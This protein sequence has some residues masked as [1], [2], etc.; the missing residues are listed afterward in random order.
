LHF[1]SNEFGFLAWLLDL[2]FFKMSSLHS[3]IYK[4]GLQ[5]SEDSSA[6]QAALAMRDLDSEYVVIVDPQGNWV[7]LVSDRDLACHLVANY[8]MPPVPLS[9]LMTPHP[10]YVKETAKV[11]EV[12]HL[13]EKYSIQ[14][15]PV[16]TELAS[17]GLKCIGVITLEDL[18][19]SGEVDLG[20]LSRIVKKR[21]IQVHEPKSIR[22]AARSL[23]RSQQSLQEFYKIVSRRTGLDQ[24]SSE[25][26]VDFVLSAL[27]QRI[28]PSA[29]HNFI[30]QLPK[31]MQELL[32]SLPPGPD[33]KITLPWINAMISSKFDIV[34]S[35][36]GSISAS[37][38][39]GITDYV[40][41][42]ELEH[43]L[44]QLPEPI[45]KLFHAEQSAQ[46]AS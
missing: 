39:Q 45:R 42:G 4:K 25:P 30:A 20:D 11:A 41:P 15:V 31:K 29:A 2:M 37:I 44:C 5:L 35:D 12:I 46:A 14:F 24:T 28:T 21:K 26:V 23:A 3:L 36:S 17:G 32:L 16:V 43:L 9:Q 7:G 6:Q 38:F 8:P 19:A 40:D 13:M 18:I 27:V 34:P 22:A 1:N 33:R 10:A